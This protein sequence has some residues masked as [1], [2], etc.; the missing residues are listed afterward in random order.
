[1][2]NVDLSNATAHWLE[3]VN[4]LPSLLELNLSSCGIYHLPQTLPLVNFTSLSVLDISNNVFNSSIPPWLFNVTALTELNLNYCDLKGSIPKIAS[5]SLCNLR[6]LDVS[7]NFIISGPII[8]FIE[9]LSGCGN[10]SLEHLNLV[11]NQ[12]SGNLPDSLGYFKH[13]RKLQLSNNSF[14]GPIPSCIQNLSLLE[15][16][17]LSYNM[18]NGTIPEYIGQLTKLRMLDLFSNSWQ[19]IMTETHFLN[20]T[21]LC[22]LSLSSTK[23]LLV[24]NMTH[25]WIPPFSLQN[26]QIKDCQLGP[27]FP[28][29]LRTQ[30]ELSEISLVNT[31]I[32][33][34]IPNWLW[35]LSSSLRNLELSHNNLRGELPKSLSILWVDLSYNNLTGSLPLWPNVSYILLRRNLLSGPIP[36]NIFQATLQLI[37][38]DLSG[39]FL[40]G[41]I[42]SLTHGPTSL[43][44]VDLSNNL[45][46]GNIPS[47]WSGMQN[48]GAIDLSKNNLSGEIPSSLCS[49]NTLGWLQLSYNNLSG[50]LFH[51][52]QNCS[53][54]YALDLGDNIFSGTIPKWIGGRLPLVSELRLRG[55]MLSGHVVE[56]LCR[57]THLHVL[58]LSHYNFS[59][60]IPTCLGNLVGLKSLVEYLKSPIRSFLIPLSYLEHMDLSTKGTQLEYFSQ[61]FIVNSRSFE[62]QS[63][64]RD[65]RITNKSLITVYLKF[66]MESFDWKD[67][68]EYRSTTWIRNS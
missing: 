26:V 62:K 13:L 17:D 37:N 27:A 9:A 29:W 32:S 44:F 3:V 18:M 23:S 6:I 43:W 28:T 56:E 40:T 11:S 34:T 41:R 54:L 55:N 4:M 1:M 58:D 16:L 5:G 53:S 21:E 45:L 42:P 14:S 52:L 30:N 31:S 35:N 67:T 8:E 60:S 59:G 19:G 61:I 12:F 10:N 36:E 15:T 46:S 7:F 65:S 20:L 63:H 66:V 57:L 24:L 50:D 25:D 39:N 33:A 49:L 68:K 2:Q 22:W 48:L 64:R 51:S 47:H 38:L